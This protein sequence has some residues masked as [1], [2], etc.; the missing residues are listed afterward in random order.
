MKELELGFTPNGTIY[1]LNK[2]SDLKWERSVVAAFGECESYGILSL[3]KVKGHHSSS[4]SFV[5]GISNELFRL[6]S[7]IPEG[8]TFSET[9][10][11]VP[12]SDFFA[13]LVMNV[14]L[15][16]GAEYVSVDALENVWERL[17]KYVCILMKKHDSIQEFLS[18]YAPTWNRVGRVTLHL[19][20][21][22]DDTVFPF[23]FIATYSTGLTKSGKV[24]QVPMEHALKEYANAGKTNQMLNLLSPLQKASEKSELMRELI[25][26]SDIYYPLAWSPSET[27][28]FMQDIP[29]YEDCGLLV[30]LQDWWKKKNKP[31]VGVEINTG[32]K[33]VLGADSLMSF[34]VNVSVDGNELTAEEVDE[35]LKT[36]KIGLYRIKG[37]W[38]EVDP[39]KLQM[40]LD[41]W[42]N[43]E[44][45]SENNLDFATAMR[46]LS[47]APVDSFDEDDE[48]DDVREWTYTYAG[49]ELSEILAVLNQEK[50][51]KLKPPKS[52]N[53]TLRHY[54]VDGVNWLWTCYRLGLGCCL[55]DDMGLGKTIQILT[56]LLRYKEKVSDGA[57][58]LLVVPASL[59]GNWKAESAKF[60]PDL[61]IVVA[62][63]SEYKRSELDKIGVQLEEKLNSVD[64]I[65]T[66]YTMATKLSWVNE[67]EWNFLILDEAQAIKNPKSKQSRGIKKI[68]ARNRIALTGT[69][70]E[71]KLIDLW[72]LFDFLNPGF[73]GGMTDF[74]SYVGK[75]SSG[76]TVNF[77]PLRKLISPY[78]LRRMKTDPSVIPDLPEKT[79]VKAY[80]GLSKS[81]VTLYQQNVNFLRD[82]LENT[83][84]PP[85]QRRGLV[86]SC[87]S[88]FKQICNHPAQFTGNLDYDE[89]LSAKFMR[90]K[91]ICG[92]IHSRGEKVLVFSQFKEMTEP[93]SELLE[94]VFEREGLVLHGS[95]AVKKRQEM[96][97]EFQKDDGPPYFVISLKAGGSG[98]NL[99]AA[100]HV[101]HFDRWWNPAVENQATDR[102]FRIGQK[103]NVIVH[104]FVTRGTIEEKIDKLLEEKKHMANQIL[105]DA[106]EFNFTEMSNSEIIDMVTLNIHKSEV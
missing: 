94:T 81:Q 89:K 106:A 105:S 43:L 16:V 100:S 46:M 102:A 20:E 63:S 3:G 6:L 42:K 97:T 80:C 96:V 28:H 86:L 8:M 19:A 33:S 60:A 27:Y 5:K 34:S 21:N 64:L 13:N 72:S 12:D 79:E 14:P 25:D 24:K 22:K 4:V 76:T 48:F 93:I 91:E 52:L 49:D 104:K 56:T 38:V 9:M 57:T 51:S 66:T 71:N 67:I 99:T 74:K 98:L 30:K 82:G 35:I 84:M 41:Y 40:A 31:T 101:I 92:E 17:V 39:E 15:M 77:A 45:T 73:L 59:L 26:S 29:I 103:R 70:V 23:A 7:H 69:P 37:N 90:L 58:S 1:A 50:K 85:M 75:L 11:A 18:I 2:N 54:Q 61:N 32:K 10:V 83:N 65:V 55:A 78:I 95:I 68:K 53:A 44:E 87:L 88:R 36:G 47:G 62:H